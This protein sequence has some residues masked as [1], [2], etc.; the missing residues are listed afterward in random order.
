MAEN[1]TKPTR[2]SVAAFIGKVANAT[3]REDARTVLA[4]MRKVSGV[5]PRMWGPSIIGFGSVHYRYASGREGEMPRSGISPR[6]ASL[7]LYLSLGGKSAPLLK[8]LGKHRRSVA[9]L[10]VNRLADI[11]MGVL[12]TMIRED[13]S[14]TYPAAG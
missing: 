12:E 10:Y 3:R 9:C 14:R 11:D 5:A 4:L 2:S 13:W 6:S 8:R 1:K 7:V